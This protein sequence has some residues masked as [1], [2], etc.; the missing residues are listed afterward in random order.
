MNV[1]RGASTITMGEKVKNLYTL[2]GESV[3]DGAIKV[4]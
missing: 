4:E 1:V 2:I 3:L